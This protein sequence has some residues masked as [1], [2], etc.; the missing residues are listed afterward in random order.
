MRTVLQMILIGVIAGAVAAGAVLAYRFTTSRAA[1]AIPAT[2]ID[3]D[4]L[5]VSDDPYANFR[6]ADFTLTDQDGQTAGPDRFEGEVTALAFFFTSCPGPCPKLMGTLSS[7]EGRTTGEDPAAA[8]RFAA[9][10]VD[11]DRDTPEVLRAYADK[12]GLGLDRW[13]LLTGDPTLVARL[14]SD[15]LNYE[16]RTQENVPISGPDGERMAN[17]LHPTRIMLIGPDRR[18]IGIYAYADPDDVD[19]LV[20]DAGAALAG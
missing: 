3:G 12:L 13:S 2:A 17:I 18:L 16:I 7:I 4:A 19:R 6:L 1:P 5:P 9:I 20:E 11:G 14:A 10:S 15:S 8:L